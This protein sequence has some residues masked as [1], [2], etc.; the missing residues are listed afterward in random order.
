[1]NILNKLLMKTENNFLN[2]DK[3]QK[4]NFRLKG[5]VHEVLLL[6]EREK[7][8]LIFSQKFGKT[9]IKEI[10]ETMKP[11]IYTSFQLKEL[12]L[13]AFENGYIQ[14]HYDVIE[15]LFSA[16]EIVRII[17][18]M[19]EANGLET[20]FESLQEELKCQPKD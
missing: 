11:F 19:I 8:N 20:M 13:K 9:T 17:K 15:M 5:E 18:F 7:K 4:V 10:Y 12:A 16:D 1:M 3:T 6:S 2:K 14:R